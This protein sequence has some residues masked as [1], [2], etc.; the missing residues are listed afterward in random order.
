MHHASA[1]ENRGVERTTAGFNNDGNSHFTAIL[2]SDGTKTER[3]HRILA[4]RRIG[5]CHPSETGTTGS[6][7]TVRQ[8]PLASSGCHFESQKRHAAL[9]YAYPKSG[10]TFTIPP[11]SGVPAH[12][13][14]RNGKISE[15]QWIHIVVSDPSPIPVPKVTT[16]AF[17]DAKFDFKPRAQESC[18]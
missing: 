17:G 1:L 5:I 13:Y 15:R 11:I 3:S 4:S 9:R 8:T 2:I 14:H 7:S 10:V 6:T 18:L 16:L 12:L